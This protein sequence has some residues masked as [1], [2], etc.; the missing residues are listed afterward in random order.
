[1]RVE[2]ELKSFVRIGEPNKRKTTKRIKDNDL[3]LFDGEK[4]FFFT[5]V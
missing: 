1:M 2:A 4:G 3:E 5:M